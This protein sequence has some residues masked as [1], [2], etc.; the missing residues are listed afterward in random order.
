[1]LLRGASGVGLG[2]GRP[3]RA[4]PHRALLP[5]EPSLSSR[6]QCTA[7]CRSGA[8]LQA[9]Q[10]A[11][12]RCR[13][14]RRWRGPTAAAA[15]AADERDGSGEQPQR[16]AGTAAW[17]ARAALCAAAVVAWGA[18][19]ARQPGG[20][21]ASLTVAAHHV[22]QEGAPDCAQP[23]RADGAACK[24]SRH[25]QAMQSARCYRCCAR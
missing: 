24:L 10:R 19:A 13:V 7:R 23:A 1:M 14:Q 12:P 17:V 16:H 11:P 15:G 21:L 25:Q 18:V 6:G 22:S 3:P 9:P 4:L 5:C 8:C 2:A 20:S